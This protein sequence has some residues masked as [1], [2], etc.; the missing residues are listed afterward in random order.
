MPR[1][2]IMLIWKIV[3]L[4]T[5]VLLILICVAAAV[6][7]WY[8]DIKLPDG[9]TRLFIT[10]GC[11]AMAFMTIWGIN[12]A[13]RKNYRVCWELIE[14]Y[15]YRSNLMGEL[16][17]LLNSY[18][19]RLSAVLHRLIDAKGQVKGNNSGAVAHAEAGDRLVDMLIEKLSDDP[20]KRMFKLD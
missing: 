3:E 9:T 14:A 16:S 8:F 7:A 11:Y 10:F 15:R 6:Q 13:A 2:S 12:S 20:S 1:T 19:R 4:A 5:D 18:D 17:F